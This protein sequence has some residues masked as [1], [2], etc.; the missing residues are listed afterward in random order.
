[1]HV[2]DGDG[3]RVAICAC[4]PEELLERTFV[5]NIAV[6][7]DG[8]VHV[9][10]FDTVGSRTSVFSA[11]GERIGSEN[12][13][14]ESI[15]EP[16]RAA[17]WSVKFG[18]IDL[19]DEGGALTKRISRSPDNKWLSNVSGPSVAADGSLAVASRGKVHVFSADGAPKLSLDAPGIEAPWIAFT[20]TH[21]FLLRGK[22]LRCVDLASRAA[23]AAVLGDEA[24]GNS[25]PFWRAELNELWILDLQ[26]RRVLRYRVET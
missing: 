19:L 14:G 3:K 15:F 2:F 1:V 23:R 4:T 10:L 18:E 5:G 8:A 24:G 16:A 6:A 9:G 11:G 25:R 7:A 26:A 22:D 17:R 12:S 21:V 13:D 20:G